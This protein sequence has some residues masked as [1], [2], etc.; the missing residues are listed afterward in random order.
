MAFCC[1]HLEGIRGEERQLDVERNEEK[2]WREKVGREM[3]DR[4]DRDIS[5]EQD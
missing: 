1:D 5:A 4:E 3:R 2:R